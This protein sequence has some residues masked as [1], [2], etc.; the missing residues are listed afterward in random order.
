[1]ITTQ[2]ARFVHLSTN[3]VLMAASK[4]NLAKLRKK[5]GY[6]FGNCKKALEENNNDLEKAEKWL[7]DQAKALG[8]SKA[9]K[10]EN[11][12]TP[13][14]LV[15]V[16]WDKQYAAMVE[17]NCETDFVSKNDKFQKLVDVVAKTCLQHTKT[18]NPSP[19]SISKTILETE[20][21]SKLLAHDQQSL[22]DHLVKTIAMVGE[23]LVLRRAAMVSAHHAVRLAALTHP[24]PPGASNLTTQMGK[25]GAVLMYVSAKGDEATSRLAKQLCQHVIGMNPRTIN[26]LPGDDLKVKPKPEKKPVSD[27]FDETEHEVE[28]TVRDEEEDE[29]TVMLKQTFLLDSDR[30][31][32][33]VVAEAGISVED[34]VR[35]ECGEG[36]AGAEEVSTKAAQ[37]GG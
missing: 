31:V 23:R 11:R 29:E 2:F 17:V 25:Y 21:V 15:G 24:T 13:Q 12:N 32:A 16:A 7:E 1:M 8:W 35:F 3:R 19:K 34:F 28:I 22:S 36:L 5:T 14:G 27:E 30:R 18:E 9:M 26:P 10:M 6:P 37:V 4:S 20:D 33:E